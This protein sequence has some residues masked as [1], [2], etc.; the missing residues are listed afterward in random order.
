MVKQIEGKSEKWT[1]QEEAD[2]KSAISR[3]HSYSSARDAKYNR[4]LNRY[5]NS[6]RNLGDASATIWSPA[7]QTIGFNRTFYDDA[8]VQ[9]RLNVIK[10][11]TDTVVSKISQAR[12]RPFFDAVRGDYQTIKAA[13]AAQDFFDQYF[14]Q[15]KI[16]ERAP[17]TA[18]S[19]MLFDAGHFW[20]DEDNLQIMPLPHWELFVNP[21][22]AN[23]GGLRGCSYGM[24]F[25]RNY[26]LALAKRQ[27]PK[28]DAWERYQSNPR[29]AVG[30]FIVFYDIDK[31]DKFFCY[32]SEIIHRK[33]ITYKRLP[34][35]AMWWSA[36]ILGWSTT[37]LADDL[38]TIQVTI[39]EIQ[40][41]IDQAMKQSPFNTVYIPE[42]SDIKAT[43]LSNE[44]SIVVPYMEGP[45]GGMPVVSTPAPISPMYSQLLDNYIQKAYEL[46][47]ISQLSAQ[48]KKPAGV[49]AGVA[50][51]TL[52]DI[53]SE[54]HNVTVQSYIH[55]FVEIAEI[56][57]EV[58]DENADVLPPAMNR[59]RIKWGDIKR[60]KD[61]FRVQF[62]A[63]SALAK[64]PATKIQQIQS[65]QALGIN[66]QPILPQLLEIPDL[67]TAYSATTASYDY[68]QAVIQ[69]AA[70][71]GDVDFLP[72]V[73]LDMLFSEAVRWM[74]R[75]SADEANK[76]YIENLNT[77][78][79]AVLEAQNAAAPQEPPQNIEPTAATPAP[80]MP[81][82]PAEGGI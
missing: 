35:T 76:K 67:E 57:V 45:G 70:E 1:A 44:S 7:C 72:I 20:I 27:F 62:S 11:A 63:G 55:Q 65:L 34:V 2:L 60:Q 41:R 51:Q 23:V 52:E 29:D 18:K 15:Q 42:G 19:A 8:T 66:L 82:I 49:T 26:P 73:N 31:G 21:Y 56:A 50:L 14:D 28:S 46:A 16:Y 58:F 75:L 25:K 78:I 39:D 43:M 32:N 53:E 33:K 38:Y 13:R 64:D 77:L 10:S 22:E 54:R 59:A 71:T 79:E 6:G 74:L 17:E 69:K 36:P 48:S 37:C 24:V 3:L 68:T 40:L 9:T 47:G 30:E 81:G 5:Y 12:V 4:N 61:L 80:A